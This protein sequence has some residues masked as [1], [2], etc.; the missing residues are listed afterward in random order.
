MRQELRSQYY[1]YFRKPL[2]RI[3][4]RVLGRAPGD[5]TRIGPPRRTAASLDEIDART[6]ALSPADALALSDPIR[7]QDFSFYELYLRGTTQPTVT[8][9]PDGLVYCAR[10]RKFVTSLAGGRAVGCNGAVVTADDTLVEELSPEFESERYVSGRHSLLTAVRL[11]PARYVPGRVAVLATL[12]SEYFAHWMM[13]LLPRVGLLEAA[14]LKLGDFDAFY[15]K[16]PEHSFERESLEAAGIPFDRILDCRSHPHIACD[17]LV[18]PSPLSEVFQA[19]RYS[20]DYLRSL[21]GPATT[22]GGGRRLYVS[23]RRTSHRRVANERDVVA[24]LTREGFVIVEPQDMSLSEQAAL[25]AEADIVVGPL[26]SAVANYVHCRPGTAIVEIQN[27]HALQTCTPAIAAERGFVYGVLLGRDAG[28]GERGLAQDMTVD[29]EELLRLIERTA[30]S[31][32]S[33][34]RPAP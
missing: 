20:C 15:L 9:G 34:G 16:H 12:G 32:A 13:D 2:R 5:S 28:D 17:E 3:A 14:G 29:P 6:I 31:R 7:V 27:A 10:P 21:F 23:R 8:R 1:T 11:P 25:F 4:S 33:A 24:A 30:A 26:G 22:G 18:V 19:S